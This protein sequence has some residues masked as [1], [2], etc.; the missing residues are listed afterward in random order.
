[1]ATLTFTK[2]KLD[3]VE[4][5]NS[6]IALYGGKYNI[7]NDTFEGN[8]KITFTKDEASK[9]FSKMLSVYLKSIPPEEVIDLAPAV[10]IVENNVEMAFVPA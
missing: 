9:W 6:A 10:A 3:Q 5:A 7:Y 2:L 1:M 4:F 8:L